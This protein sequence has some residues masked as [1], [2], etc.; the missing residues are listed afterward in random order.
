M[1]TSKT[2]KGG[3]RMPPPQTEAPQQAAATDRAGQQVRLDISNLKSSYCNV[4]NV[5]STR[6]E[7]ILNF[8][9]NTNWDRGQPDFE[10]QLL[11]RVILSPYAAKRLQGVL[12]NLIREHE[13]RYGELK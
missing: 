5:T 8:G 4:C 10:V 6:E 12:T 9:I 11:Y 7:V 2:A 3:D 13:T 1:T